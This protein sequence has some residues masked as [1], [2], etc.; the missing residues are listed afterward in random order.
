MA[1][2]GNG[3]TDAVL[4]VEQDANTMHTMREYLTRAKFRVHAAANGWDALK[5][6]QSAP[7]DLV[8]SE[9]EVQDMDGGHLRQKFLLTPEH[10]DVPFLFLVP[11]ERRDRQVLALRSGVDDCISKPFDPFVL[12]A[13]VQAVLE[14]RRSYE[15]MVRVDPLT[16]M[17]NRSTLQAEVQAELERLQRY[18]RNAALLLLA[19]DNFSEISHQRG[20]ALGDLL[21]TCLAGLLMSNL[22]GMDIAGRLRGEHFLLCLPETDLAGAS[23]LLHRTQEQ[24]GALGEALAGQQISFSC[25]MAQAPDHGTDFTLVSERLQAALARAREFS[26]GAMVTWSEEL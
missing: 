25:G 26:I 6:V 12:V 24:L 23:T 1:I 9:Y 15:Q 20:G 19:I 14:R 10:R 18:D 16:R 17:L 21:L 5:C 4:L 7:I 8:I 3:G 11:E 22:R 13:R 2:V